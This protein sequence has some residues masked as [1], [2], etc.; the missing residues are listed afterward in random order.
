MQ[1]AELPRDA[2]R[3]HAALRQETKQFENREQQNSR[4]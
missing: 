2:V 3:G 4:A 1:L